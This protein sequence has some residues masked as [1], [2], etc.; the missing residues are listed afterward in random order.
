MKSLFFSKAAFAAILLF[1]CLSFTPSKQRSS[2]VA[3]DVN[4]YWYLDGGT[5]YDGWCS[6][7]AEIESLEERYGVYVD[8]DS[9]D[10]TV[11]AAGYAVKGYPH[12]V[13]ASV[14]L[15]TH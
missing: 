10:G 4:Y 12:Y 14:F 3:K 1:F 8:T 7:S 9:D 15:Y 2:V 13:Y 11:I 6:V 5:V